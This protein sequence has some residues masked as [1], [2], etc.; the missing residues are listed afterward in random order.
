ML[1]RPGYQS[2][3]YGLLSSALLGTAYQTALKYCY[4]SFGQQVQD[5]W[6]SLQ[7]LITSLVLDKSSLVFPS[8]FESFPVLLLN[9]DWD[10]FR[11]IRKHAQ[12]NKRTSHSYREQYRCLNFLKHF[13]LPHRLPV[14]KARV[15][16]TLKEKKY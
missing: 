7:P 8:P 16:D 3:A 2:T 4:V 5:V 15:G 12:K 13:L 14:S 9:L 10:P 11:H 6:P 1:P